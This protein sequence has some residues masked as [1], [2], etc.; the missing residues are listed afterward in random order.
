M[1]ILTLP[2]A[3]LDSRRALDLPEHLKRCDSRPGGVLGAIEEQQDSVTAEGERV[4]AV[5]RGG[6][7]HALEERVDD[8]GQAFGALVAQAGEPF[9]E[10]R[11]P[12]EVGHDH[13]AVDLRHATEGRPRAAPRPPARAEAG[14]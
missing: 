7:E 10:R 9:G 13:G 1:P 8:A 2:L 3:G 5:A 4:A 14:K 11:E 6:L 12:R